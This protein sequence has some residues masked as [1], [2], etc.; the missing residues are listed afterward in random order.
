MSKASNGVGCRG[1][2]L[3]ALAGSRGRAP[4][5][6]QGAAPRELLDF[7]ICKGPR[8]ALLEIFFSLNQPCLKFTLHSELTVINWIET[9]LYHAADLTQE[10]LLLAQNWACFEHYLKKIN[11][12]EKWFDYLEANCPRKFKKWHSN[13]RSSIWIIDW[14]MQ[15][16]VCTWS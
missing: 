14:N 2:L 1:P 3:G 8:K 7:S 9:F 11:S 16:I 10:E 13:F 15:N 4:A 12:F 5:G 6:V